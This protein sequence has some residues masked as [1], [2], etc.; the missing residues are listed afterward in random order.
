MSQ[1]DSPD[2]TNPSRRPLSAPF[3]DPFVSD[4]FR[5]AE[6]DPGEAFAIPAPSVPR[7]AGGAAVAPPVEAGEPAETQPDPGRPPRSRRLGDRPRHRPGRL[8]RSLPGGRR[9]ARLC[10]RPRRGHRT[11]PQAQ[12]GRAACLTLRGDA[13]PIAAEDWPKGGARPCGGRAPKSRIRACR[14]PQHSGDIS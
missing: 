2:N 9:R 5:R 11:A 4:A 3:V 13:P 10:Q 12:E 1:A 6:G 8:A 7:L 14:Q